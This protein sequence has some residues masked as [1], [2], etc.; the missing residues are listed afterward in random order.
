MVS[1]GVPKEAVKIKMNME[2]LDGEIIFLEP[3]TL[4]TMALK[5]NNEMRNI[6]PLPPPPMPS[7]NLQI[8][9]KINPSDLIAVKLK[10]SLIV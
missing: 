3:T 9:K 7:N 4:S 1:M 2:G 8:P 10:Y 6:H 5:K